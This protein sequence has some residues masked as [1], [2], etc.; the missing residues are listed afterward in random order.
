MRESDPKWAKDI[1]L[2]AC[3]S[4]LAKSIG[5][6]VKKF[7]WKEA[8][9]TM[10]QPAFVLGKISL[11]GNPKSSENLKKSSGSS[12]LQWL[13]TKAQSL[14]PRNVNTTCNIILWSVSVKYS[15]TKNRW[16]V[17]IKNVLSCGDKWGLYKKQVRST[18]LFWRTAWT[19]WQH[20]HWIQSKIF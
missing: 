4:K 8:K 2:P 11:R 1:W 19:G 18:P 5:R 14:K 13:Y 7:N 15:R 3:E 10:T 17:M 6:T 12:R 16:D 20:H 9:A